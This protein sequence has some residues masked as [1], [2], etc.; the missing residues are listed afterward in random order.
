MEEKKKKELVR[1]L[2]KIFDPLDKKIESEFTTTV[3]IARKRK[4]R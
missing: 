1:K 4:K 3:Y 2:I